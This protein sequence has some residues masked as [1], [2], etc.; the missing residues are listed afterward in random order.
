MIKTAG[1]YTLLYTAYD[2]LGNP[3]A[4]TYSASFIVYVGDPYKLN[5]QAEVGTV[6]GG[7]QFRSFPIVAI[8]DRGSNP[9]TSINSGTVSATLSTRPNS[10]LYP[11]ASKA[12]LR[13]L[14]STS[15]K[16]SNGLA[17]F[18]QL[19]INESGYPYQLTFFTSL[20][21]I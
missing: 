15:V 21:S 8:T 19:Y 1:N 7:L 14:N 10:A 20:V 3:I 9:I 18:S 17:S 6:Y 13:P 2:T 12:S 16:I 5:F 11:A 4:S